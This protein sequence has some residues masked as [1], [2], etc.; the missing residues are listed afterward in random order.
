[1]YARSPE[2]AASGVAV[3]YGTILV[4]VTELNS[5]TPGWSLLPS[6]IVTALLPQSAPKGGFV[7]SARRCVL[8]L[9][10]DLQAMSFG[11]KTLWSCKVLP[12]KHHAW[13]YF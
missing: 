5:Q 8:K 9:A 13:E 7:N 4:Q 11:A 2:A 1:M 3:E 12:R 10:A 6:A